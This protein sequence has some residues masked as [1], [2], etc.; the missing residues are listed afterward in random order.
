MSYASGTWTLTK[1]HERMIQ[2]TQRKMLRLI[3]QT[4]RKYKKKTQSKDE[5]KAKEGNENLERWKLGGG[6]ENQGGSEGETED[7]HNSNTNCDQDSD[8]SF[9]NDTDDEINTTEIEEEDWI[10]YMKR[11]TDE[12]MERMKT[13]K[14]QC[15]IKTHRRKK[16][17]LATRIASLPKERWMVKAAVWNPELS[18]TEQWGDQEKDGKTRL[19]NSSSLEKLNRRQK[20][21]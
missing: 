19:M 21:I 6:E 9:R 5:D 20:V 4:K 3:T 2:S 18:T 8:I 16:W 15:W 17:R 14:I 1:E 13:T 10:E 11:S 12:A 7:G